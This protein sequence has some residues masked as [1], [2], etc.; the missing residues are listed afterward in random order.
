MVIESAWWAAAVRYPFRQSVG[1]A[2]SPGAGTRGPAGF[3]GVRSGGREPPV[4]ASL[5]RQGTICPV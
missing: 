5:T 3:T 1:S 4:V 2:T